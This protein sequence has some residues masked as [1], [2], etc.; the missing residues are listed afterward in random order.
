[1][2]KVYADVAMGTPVVIY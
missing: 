2:P 1:M